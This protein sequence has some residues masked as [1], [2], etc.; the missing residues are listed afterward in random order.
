MYK[1]GFVKRGGTNYRN[2]QNISYPPC[3]QKKHIMLGAFYV[4][5]N[6]FSNMRYCSS[7]TS[8]NSPPSEM[9][10]LPLLFF[11]RMSGNV[12]LMMSYAFPVL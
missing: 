12:S 6:S 4:A 1:K 8:L 5:Y 10:H 9:K 3:I 11:I 7:V 2:K